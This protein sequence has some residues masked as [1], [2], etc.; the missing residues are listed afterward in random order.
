MSIEYFHDEV[1][2]YV[3]KVINEHLVWIIVGSCTFILLSVL[4]IY[5]CI[6][7]GLNCLISIPTCIYDTC[8]CKCLNWC[9]GCC[10]CFRC[11]FDYDPI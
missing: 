7:S 10:R 8:T 3:D 4:F 5:S 11:C 1:E 6:K 2:Q 9:N